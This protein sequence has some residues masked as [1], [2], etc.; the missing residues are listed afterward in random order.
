VSAGELRRSEPT[1]DEAAR[2][3]H[4]K[5]S[6]NRATLI[7]TV[8]ALLLSVVGA[9]LVSED[10]PA[11]PLK[12]VRDVLAYFVQHPSTAD[13]LEGIARWRVQQAT[14]PQIVEQVDQA[15]RWLVKQHLLLRED[16]IGGAATFRLD[17]ARAGEA[18]RLLRNVESRTARKVTLRRDSIRS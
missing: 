1:R 6:H 16:R 12:S 3:F 14:V 5:R 17:P 9:R 8:F 15:L 13:S 11:T 18:K 7:G 2:W 10:V 4:K